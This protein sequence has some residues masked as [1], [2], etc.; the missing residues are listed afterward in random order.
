MLLSRLTRNILY[1]QT[2]QTGSN[3]FEP[4][5]TTILKAEIPKYIWIFFSYY[6][7]IVLTVKLIS[8][9]ANQKT[10]LM[11]QFSEDSATLY[12]KRQE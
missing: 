4:A 12:E 5:I 9:N 2:T 3:S 6:H 8:K 11:G 1:P 7:K 10:K